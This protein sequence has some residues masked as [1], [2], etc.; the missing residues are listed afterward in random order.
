MES[1]WKVPPANGGDQTAPNPYA[2]RHVRAERQLVATVGERFFALDE[3]GVARGPRVCSEAEVVSDFESRSSR[4]EVTGS[5]PATPDIPG[6]RRCV[7]EI[8][9]MDRRTATSQDQSHYGHSMATC[10][11]TSPSR[12]RTRA[13]GKAL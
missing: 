1:R 2:K 11:A 9:G 8:N 5:V 3:L 12:A 6:T 10:A 4:T 7:A 13:R